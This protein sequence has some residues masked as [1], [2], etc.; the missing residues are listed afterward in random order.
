MLHSFF[1]SAEEFKK[2]FDLESETQYTNYQMLNDVKVGFSVQRTY[3]EDI[4]YIPP[5]TKENR[6]DTLA[7]IHVVYIHPKESIETFNTNNVPLILSI[8]SYS[9][10]LANNYDYNF[11]DENCPTQESIKIS[12]TTN[13]PISLDFIDDYFFNH[14][15]NTI[16]N[17]N[18]NTFTGRQV[19][20]YVFKRHCDTVHWRKGFKLR[21]KIRSHR[22][23]MSVYFFIDRIITDL[24][25]STLKNV[26]G[27]T[28]ESKHPFSTIFNGYSKNDLKLL[29]TDAMNIFGY[30]ASKNFI[31]FFCLLSFCIY[32]IFYFLEIE[33]KFLKGMFSNSLLSVTNGIL[34]LA[35]IDIV[36]PKSVFWLL[37]WII[38]LRKKISYKNFKF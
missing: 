26:F 11:D 18:G 22:L 38:K 6:P 34:L 29:K 30:K 15:K 37:N 25:K 32:T 20:D 36:G 28:L 16:I 7:L 31:F 4:R 17:K 12:K 1:E 21:F 13:K 14:E 5:K 33:N 2:L 8:S 3:P 9:L 23:L 10:Y 35:L 24:C 19:L 27:R